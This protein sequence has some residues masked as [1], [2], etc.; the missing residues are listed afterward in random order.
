MFLRCLAFG[1]VAALA[2]IPWAMTFGP[3][4]GHSW[5]LAGYCLAV[6]SLF[7]VAIAPTWPHGVA[8]GAAAGFVALAVCVLAGRPAE[9]ILGAALIVAVARSGFLYRAGPARAVVVEAVLVF[10]GLLAARALAG[11]TLLGAG[12]AI[13]AF[14][15]VQSLFFL[16]GGVRERPPDEP[17]IDPFER[18][19]KRALAVMEGP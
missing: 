10:G 11:P 2:S 15:L 9:A 18:A 12:L 4:L 6:A 13:W 14:F 3:L 16:I 17:P 1:L 7:V 8:T 19:R 5:A